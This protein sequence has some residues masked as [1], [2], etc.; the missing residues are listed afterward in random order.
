[1]RQLQLTIFFIT[2]LMVHQ[3]VTG[4]ST[5][6]TT[7]EADT[8][9]GQKKATDPCQYIPGPHD[10]ETITATG[11][12]ITTAWYGNSTEIYGHGVLGDAVEAH[13]LLSLIHI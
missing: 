2:T 7:K 9:S 5:E 13:T 4:Q 6:D 3:L 10:A 12:G 1:M 11:D 8:N